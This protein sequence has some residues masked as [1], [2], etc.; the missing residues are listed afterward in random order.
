[1]GSDEVKLY[2]SKG[3]ERGRARA[4]QHPRLQAPLATGVD[5]P[6]TPSW[7]ERK[8]DGP[9]AGVDA[10]FP[11]TFKVKQVEGTANRIE[12]VRTSTPFRV[13]RGS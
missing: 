13:N 7:P 1:M 9:L 11:R 6:L 2:A 10:S 3:R 4:E 5:V 12:L 8:V